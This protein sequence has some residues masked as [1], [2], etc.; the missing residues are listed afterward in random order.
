MCKRNLRLV[1]PALA[2]GLIVSPASWAL[3]A[4]SENFESLNQAD[5][6]A[7]ANAG[8]LAFGNVFDSGGNFLFGYGPFG[9]PNGGP[10]FSAIANGQGG[11]A[12]GAQQL[13]VY[14][15]YNC[16]QPS[17]GHFN[18]TDL[19]ESNVFQEQT[20]G[21]GDVGSTW[22]FQFDAKRG[23]ITGGSTALAFIKTLDPN[24][25]FATTN[26]LTVDTTALGTDW[27]TFSIAIAIDAALT[28]Q[29]LQFGFLSVAANF[30]SSGNF[31]DNVSFSQVPVPAAAWL[32]L[33]G[34]AGL[35]AMRKRK[36]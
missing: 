9:T 20:V 2:A 5:G 4:F 7:L 16:C 34:I 21:A 8:W 12:Q 23:D 24:A 3:N 32:F 33:S 1:L 27:S 18:G 30:E 14:N 19:V 36:A 15:D 11:P 6:A 28:G 13:V 29:I 31:Y 26:F 10:G 35:A 25:G 22:E 17:N